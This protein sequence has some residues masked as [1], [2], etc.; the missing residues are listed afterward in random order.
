MD[1]GIAQ[2]KKATRRLQEMKGGN[3]LTH[4]AHAASAFNKAH[5]GSTEAPPNN[6]SAS[7]IL[8]QSKI[9][10]QSAAHNMRE[11]QQ[12]KKKLEKEEEFRT[13][14]E[15]KRE[16]KRRIDESTWSK[17][18]HQVTSFTHPAT[19]LDEEGMPVKTKRVLAVLWIL[20]AGS[21]TD[22]HNRQSATICRR[23]TRNRKG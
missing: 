2:I 12:R 14:K 20:S 19:V 22:D 9:A 6:M 21:S 17:R 3:W 11:I 10:A 15:K 7:V 23:T 1:S 4:K 16:L 13:L 5:H 18:I 8:E